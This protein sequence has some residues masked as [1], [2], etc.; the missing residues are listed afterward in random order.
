M[1][2][3]NVSNVDFLLP[4]REKFGVHRHDVDELLKVAKELEMNVVGVS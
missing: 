3:L 1:M 4:S 2:R